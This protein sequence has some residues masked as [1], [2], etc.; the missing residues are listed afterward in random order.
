MGAEDF[1]PTGTCD[2]T[3]IGRR[4]G[5]E[6]RVEV[7]YVTVDDRIVLTG[8]PGARDWLANVRA[9]P[10][11][12]LHLRRPVRDVRVTAVEVTDAA[13]RRH[14]AEVAW[15]LQPWYA[16]QPY[17]V[18]DWVAGSPMLVLVPGA[19]VGG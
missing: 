16:E 2:L 6:R 17:S 19:P 1:P 9:R 4:S 10:E 11:A 5:A 3:T 15:R 7:W 8:T 14:V 12:V 13:E 18:D